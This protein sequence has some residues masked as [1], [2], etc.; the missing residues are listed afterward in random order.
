MANIL[1]NQNVNRQQAMQGNTGSN[2]KA[3]GSA[4]GMAGTIASGIL[5]LVFPPA[6]PIVGAVA[7]IASAGL[8]LAGSVA[9]KDV[10]GAM[11]SVAGGISSASKLSGG[12]DA[13]NQNSAPV[14]QTPKFGFMTG[15][16]PTPAYE[17]RNGIVPVNNQT[18][19]SRQVMFG[20]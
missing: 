8:G 10:G 20:M 7:G 5:S 16:T 17:G 9:D 12:I 11:S 15:A 3:A 13:L 6:A 1:Q 2:L 4:V 19:F 14:D 18:G